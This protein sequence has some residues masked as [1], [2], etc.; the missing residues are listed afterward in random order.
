VKKRRYV[1]HVFDLGETELL[2]S[3]CMWVEGVDLKTL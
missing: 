1:V 3:S 2:R